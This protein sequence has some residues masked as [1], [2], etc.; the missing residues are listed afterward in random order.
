MVRLSA[1]MAET[2]LLLAD[3]AMKRAQSS[4]E[5][6]A[7]IQRLPAN[8]APLDGP[9]DVDDAVS[10]FFN[11]VARIARF[12]MET[13]D[14]PKAWEQL[15][16]A[17]RSSFKYVDWKDPRSIVLPLQIPLSVG[18]LLT[19]QSMRGLATL[20]VVG[21]ERYP[22]FLANIF[23]M[24][25]EL[26][27]YVGLQYTEII[28]RFQSRLAEAPADHAARAELGRVLIKCGRY[29]E[30]AEHL[31]Q[32]SED[33]E[34][35]PLALHEWAVA[36]YRS[37]R[38]KEAVDA[39]SQ[40]VSANPSDVR[41][42]NW[43]WICAQKLGGYPEYIP[44][45]NRL[46]TKAG[47]AAPTVEF[48]DIAAR[49]GLDKTSGGRGTAIFDYN[50][51]GYLDVFIAASMGGCGLYRNNG[52]GTF[53]DVSIESGV[54]GC[55]NA[56]VAAAGDY[57]NDGYTDLFITRL[58]FYNGEGELWRNNGDGTFTNVTREAGLSCWGP[59][60][61]ATWV[62]FDCDGHLDLFIANNLGGLFDRKI[63]NRLFHNN[64]DGTFTE[65]TERSGIATIWPTIGSTW[66]DYDNDGY[67]DLFLSCGMGRSQLFHNNGD[68]TFTDV[69][70]KAGFIDF[71]V[72]S[73]A[74]FCDV[75]NDGWLDIVQMAW[76]DHEDMAY[77]L[78]HGSG[79]AAGNPTRI[80]RN[81]RDGTFT[82]VSREYGITECWGTMS[83]NAGDFNNDGWLD[84]ALGNGSPRMDRLEPLVLMESDGQT[85]R[86]IT[87]AA[88]L[89]P[90]GKSHGVNLGD[91]FGD[92]RLS[93]LVASGGAYPGELITAS[94]WCPRKL[95]GNYLNVRLSGTRSNRS[96]IGARLKLEAD[97]REQHRVI[98]GGSNFGCL[99]FEQHFG[100]GQATAID[101]LEIR[102][103]SGLTQRF[104]NPPVNRTISI[105]EGAGAWRDVYPNVPVAAR[106]AGPDILGTDSAPA[107]AERAEV[108]P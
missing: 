29:D 103:P 107:V 60:F 90:N 30:A 82:R 6:F 39:A 89:P 83:G 5:A 7:G 42:R 54:D 34:V 47:W 49:I 44:A 97:G 24:F 65:V 74:F 17:V 36:L 2:G 12:T 93:I 64:G 26:P 101:A 70:T 22:R 98:N 105:D 79:P 66:G 11:R 56:F 67:P 18:T 3:S 37:G 108:G 84:L 72:T 43:L 91:L 50:N 16:E 78:Q 32:A 58:G 53:T 59:G 81:N 100:L 20:D 76:S 9:R 88:G 55:V 19:Q 46:E 106:P 33:P 38:Y 1:G 31:R 14:A 35:R 27:V 63:Q 77:T 51:D 61:T 21:V 48:E 13:S 52:D 75:D 15:L 69:S 95:P 92:G 80:F 45:E 73:V 40:A 85:F 8:Q 104:D 25:S 87:F 96:A 86:N 94:V 71:G 99:P 10:D 23:E 4:L 28:E 57:N 41:P 68:G 62:D 102:W